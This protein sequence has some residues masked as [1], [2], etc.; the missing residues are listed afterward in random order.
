MYITRVV[1]DASLY[2]KNFFFREIKYSALFA[3]GMRKIVGRV[4]FG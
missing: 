4:R 3:H 1:Q 2:C